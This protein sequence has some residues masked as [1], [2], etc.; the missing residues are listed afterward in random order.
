MSHDRDDLMEPA[1]QGDA[2]VVGALLVRELPKLR[3]FVRLRMNPG[4]RAREESADLVSSICREILE[5]AER[6]QHQGSENFR[7]WLFTTA[8]R[9]LRNKAKFWNRDRRAARSERLPGGD[10]DA[11]MAAACRS[12]LTPSRDASA[13]EQL[14]RLERAFE[15]LPEEHREVIALARVLGLSHKEVAEQMGRSE[16]ATRSLLHRALAG[17]AEAL[18]P[19]PG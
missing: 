18:G 10:A 19:S 7:R 4:L 12:L 1:S 8:I 11:E 9:L 2:D 16:L 17:L 14:D 6:F 15:Q 5:H 3:A 13:H